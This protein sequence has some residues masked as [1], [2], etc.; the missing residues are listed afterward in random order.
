A[1]GWVTCTLFLNSIPPPRLS[2]LLPYTPLFRSSELEAHEHEHRERDHGQR[3]ADADH[4]A[5]PALPSRLGRKG[6]RERRIGQEVGVGVADRKSTR[7]NSSHVKNSY[8]VFC[9][10]KKRSHRP[11]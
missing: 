7:L 9:L 4:L 10:T 1:V 2:M 5:D 3:D 8:A 11:P 6:R